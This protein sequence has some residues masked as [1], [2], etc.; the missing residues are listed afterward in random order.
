MA[1]SVPDALEAPKQVTA[2]K[3]VEVLPDALRLTDARRKVLAAAG[4][5]PR[6]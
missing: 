6:L 4:E 2:Y 1:L 5:T 3:K